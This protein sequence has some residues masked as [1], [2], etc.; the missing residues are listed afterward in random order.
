MDFYTNNGKKIQVDDGIYEFKFGS[1]GSIFRLSDDVCLKKYSED[2]GS[3]KTIFDDSKTRI[4]EEMFNFFKE[5]FTN[6][7]FCVLY[8]LLFD[9]RLKN[10]LGYT[11]KYYNETEDNLLF[12]PCEYLLDNFNLLF[13][14]I[15]DLTGNN[16]KVVDLNAKN[17]I[18]T[19]DKMIVI[20]FD[21]YRKNKKM[22]ID[23]LLNINMS[24]LMYTFKGLFKNELLKLGFD[25]NNL[26]VRDRLDD[27]FS[28]DRTPKSLSKKISC[29]RLIDLF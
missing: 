9:E 18:M 4:N 28:L 10:I 19:R 16:I 17:I 5:E 15:L 2:L 3:L 24:A 29:K 6:P 13:N 23:T 14:A 7:N 27:L 12:L 25:I 26:C 20:D 21:K 11:M 8:E 1:Q 22:D